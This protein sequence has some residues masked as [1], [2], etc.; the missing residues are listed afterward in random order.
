MDPDANLA[1]QRKLVAR[2]LSERITVMDSSTFGT[3]LAELV[4][5]LDGWIVANGFLPAS[6]RPDEPEL[7]ERDPIDDNRYT[8]PDSRALAEALACRKRNVVADR[9]DA[10]AAAD[11][12]IG[13][14]VLTVL[15]RQ[16]KLERRTVAAEFGRGLRD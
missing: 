4:N 7:P 9:E 11:T 16:R 6:W 8:P 13:G 5:A 12:P 15:D 10:A 3:R 14:Q 2:L 1:E